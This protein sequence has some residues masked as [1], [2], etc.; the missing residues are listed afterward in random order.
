MSAARHRGNERFLNVEHWLAVLLRPSFHRR[1][2]N[3]RN[4]DGRTIR[5]KRRQFAKVCRNQRHLG[6]AV[7][8]QLLGVGVLQV[9]TNQQFAQRWFAGGASSSRLAKSGSFCSESGEIGLKRRTCLSLA[10]V[11]GHVPP[12]LLVSRIYQ[13]EAADQGRLGEGEHLSQ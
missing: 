13:N 1:Q 5:P 10:L 4:G 11:R 7:A 8:E 6:S 12:E 2:H 9:S 3:S